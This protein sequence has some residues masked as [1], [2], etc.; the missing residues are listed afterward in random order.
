M[1]MRE[2]ILLGAVV[3]ALFYAGYEWGFKKAAKEG[4]TS[5]VAAAEKVLAGMAAQAGEVEKE[6]LYAGLLDAAVKPWPE[7]AFFRASAGEEDV[8]REALAPEIM[9]TPEWVY[10]GYM[11]LGN[12]RIAVISGVE[13]AKGEV[14]VG[15]EALRVAAIEEERVVLAG[16]QG[17]KV[18]LERMGGE[19]W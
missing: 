8:K 16:P 19:T 15:Q 5:G 7:D 12:L 18:I 3:L 17:Q 1:N 14:L 2:K 6:G 11:A 13:Y 9:K 4:W 10:M